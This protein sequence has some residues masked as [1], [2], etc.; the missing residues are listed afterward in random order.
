MRSPEEF[1]DAGRVLVA[2]AYFALICLFVT[3]LVS[4]LFYGR[5]LSE[6]DAYQKT[7]FVV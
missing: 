6:Y 5:V 7:T 1:R 4:L 2:V 3:N